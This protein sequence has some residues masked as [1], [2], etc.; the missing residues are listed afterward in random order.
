MASQAGVTGSRAGPAGDARDR[1][2]FPVSAAAGWLEQFPARQVPRSWPATEL[3]RAEVRDRL[4]SPPFALA[5]P[6]GQATRRFGLVRVLDWLEQQPGGTWQERWVASGADTAGNAGWRLLATRWLRSTG[7]GCQDPAHDHCIFGSGVLPL[8]CADVIRPSLSWLITPRTPRHLVAELARARDPDGFSAL[9]GL[10]DAE[11]LGQSAAN[12]AR[13]QV[14]TILAAKGGTIGDITVGD[15]VELLHLI[16]ASGNARHHT[17]LRFYQLLHAM[18]VFPASAPATMRAFD[19]RGQLTAAQLIGRYGIECQPVRGLLVEYLRE[20]Q[21][22]VDYSTLENLALSLGKLFWRDLELHHPGIS[23]LRLPP[24]VASG[25]KRRIA[26]KTT[27]ARTS[28][29]EVTEISG[30]R[31]GAL[32]HLATVRAFYLDI[33]QWAMEDPARWGQWAAPCPVRDEDLTRKKEHRQRKSR[34][35]QRTRERMPVLPALSAA[36]DRARQETAERL[37][38]ARHASPGG[39]FTAAGQTLR[40]PVPGSGRP[41]ARVWAEHP[42]TGQRRNLTLEEH[43][44]FWAWATVEVLRMTGIRVEELTEL[45]HHSLIQ[46]KLPAT[47]ELIPLLHIAPSK[48]DAERLL[49]VGPELAE[50]LSAIICRI[51]D[52][53]G[54]VPLVVA[55]DMHELVWLP[56]MPLLF[57][58]RYGAETRPIPAHAIRKILHAAL[59][60]AGLTSASGTPLTFTPHDFRRLWITEAVMHGMPPHIAQLICGHQT[61]TATMGYKAVYPEEAINGHRAFIARRRAVRPSE[62]YRTPSDEEWEEFL[63]HFERRKL[64]LGDCGRAWGTSCIHE[65]S[66]LRCP[67]LRIDPAQRPRLEAIRGNLLARITEAEREG[68]HGEAEGLKV[69]LAGAEQKLAQLDALATR[70]ATVHLGMPAFPGIAARTI[71][72]PDPASPAARIPS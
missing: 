17:S 56:P 46:Y 35:D 7:R 62:E 36:V 41:G 6:A 4:L 45:S 57:Q 63:G 70:R 42:A 33:A 10:C 24:E 48:T 3:E 16:R 30:P 54:T 55:Y 19:A 2:R 38:A 1:S 69:S 67:L 8:I 27:R 25:W 64:A 66:C 21:P 31:L 43:Q 52:K 14:A 47:G 20:R 61:I 44:A 11:P 59:A 23:S 72:T 32:N 15:C 40:R 65:H 26:T 49:V 60:A 34:M 5:K 51:R 18:G 13:Y 68:W 12:T 53:D 22:A 28:T 9:T 39:L 37:D 71:T 29:G 50:V 58:R